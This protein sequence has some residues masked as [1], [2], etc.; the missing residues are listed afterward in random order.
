MWIGGFGLAIG[1][2]FR[3]LLSLDD[4]SYQ[5]KKKKNVPLH[6]IA[7]RYWFE[8][9]FLFPDITVVSLVSLF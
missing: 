5:M 7:T 3:F 9:S 4:L 6:L 1:G 8:L 2:L